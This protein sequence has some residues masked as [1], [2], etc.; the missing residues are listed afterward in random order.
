MEKSGAEI[1]KKFSV[2]DPNKLSEKE[3][4]K[5]TN[6]GNICLLIHS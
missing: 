3:P 6:L 5:L 2:V 1:L 4:V